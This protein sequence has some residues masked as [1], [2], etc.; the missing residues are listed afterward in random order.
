[1]SLVTIAVRR[2]FGDIEANFTTQADNLQAALAAAHTLAGMDAPANGTSS[3]PAAATTEKTKATAEKPKA[4]AKKQTADSAS[5]APG[6]TP[7][8]TAQPAAA[9]DKTSSTTGAQPNT[10]AGEEVSYD[11][12]KALI[13]TI[14]S[15]QG[16]DKVTALLQ[17]FGAAKGPELKVEQYAEFVGTAQKVLDGEYDPVAGEE[18]L[19]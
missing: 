19:A 15:K 1:M 6:A 10:G 14:A 5:S 8:T 16:R 18:A 12:V 2:M 9:Q 3:A 17:R 11:Q 4:E 7:A 13:L